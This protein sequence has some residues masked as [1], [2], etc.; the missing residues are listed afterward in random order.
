[1]DKEE[2]FELRRKGEIL[3]YNDLK[4][5]NKFLRSFFSLLNLE[6]P[7]VYGYQDRNPSEWRIKEIKPMTLESRLIVKNYFEGLEQEEKSPENHFI[8]TIDFDGVNSLHYSDLGRDVLS[9]RV[10]KK[11]SLV[12]ALHIKP[13]RNEDQV[14]MHMQGLVYFAESC[15]CPT[16]FD[17]RFKRFIISE[18][19]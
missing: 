14:K 3:Q 9:V 18:E 19:R 17:N 5:F 7:L 11:D 2:L 12:Y 16:K 1:M 8:G 13:W 4:E 6:F 10:Q 15:I